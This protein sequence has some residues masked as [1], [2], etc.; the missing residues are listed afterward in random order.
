MYARVLYENNRMRDGNQ[1]ENVSAAF[2]A[3]ALGISYHRLRQK[4]VRKFIVKI[5]MARF[6]RD[7]SHSVIERLIERGSSQKTRVIYE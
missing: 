4:S 6:L 3:F 1:K 7:E 5:I 2:S